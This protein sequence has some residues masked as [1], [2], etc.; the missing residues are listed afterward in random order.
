MSTTAE[1]QPKVAYVLKRFPRFSETFIVNELLELRRQGLDLEVYSLLRPP[2]EAR[3]ANLEQLDVPVTYLTVR[4]PVAD[5]LLRATADGRRNER[6]TLEA[7]L[8]DLPDD[9]LVPGKDGRT[10]AHL[11]AQASAVALLARARGVT[12]LHAHFASNA[13]TVAALASRLTGI[14][15]SFTAHARDIYHAYVS[16][17]IDN[18]ARVRKIRGA[19]FAVTVS[20][21]NARHLRALASVSTDRVRRLYN[22]IDLNRFR[23]V[24]SKRAT[25]RFIAVGRLVEKKGFR[26][27]VDAC[28]LLARQPL[29]FTCH[30]VGDGPERESL[31]RHIVDCGLGDRIFLEG[32]LPQ[33]RLTPFIAGATAM[34]LP[35]Q[36][37]ASG[38]R[39]GLPTVLLEAMACGV[40]VL[41][42][43]VAGIPE[44]VDD[45]VN[46][47]LVAPGDTVSLASRMQQLLADPELADRFGTAARSKAEAT[48]DVR[49]NVAQLHDWFTACTPTDHH[50]AGDH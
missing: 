6:H 48:F 10:I 14:P 32:A 31:H 46:G 13:T 19:A 27:L 45:G 35:C 49:R 8:A 23:P 30:I 17:A 44:I 47:F 28:A 5:T 29:P 38:D 50:A 25:T 22:G 1:R 41:S 18:A 39:D 12:H 4:N 24:I 20:D 11:H 26:Q 37:T 40:P 7:A 21:Y 9:P 2:E 33:E 43:T 36:V 42:T 3:H 16:P 15:Y 34:V